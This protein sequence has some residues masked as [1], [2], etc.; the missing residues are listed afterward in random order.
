MVYSPGVVAFRQ[1]NTLSS[2]FTSPFTFNVVSAVPPNA[3]AIR[4]TYTITPE[5]EGFFEDGIRSVLL[6]RLGRALQVFQLNG[7]RALVLGAFGCGSNEVEVQM[8]ASV[9]AELLVTGEG[10]N[11]TPRFAGVFD[12]IVFA[13]PGKLHSRFK[14]AFE[15]RV[16]EAELV[17]AASD[18]ES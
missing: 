3:A 4:Q 12:K 6:S 2:K 13:L 9:F 8:V 16:F 7:N 18:P 17:A 11:G 1:D 14:H 5:T 10:H 15:M